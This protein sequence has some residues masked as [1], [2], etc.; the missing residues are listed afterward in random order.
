[1]RDTRLSEYN[2]CVY[3]YLPGFLAVGAME[4]GLVSLRKRLGTGFRLAGQSVS[5][6]RHNPGLAVY[7]LVGGVAMAAFVVTAIGGFVATGGSESLPIVVATLFGVY[8]GTSFLAAFSIA[9][10]SWAAR[11][12]FAGRDPS[13]TGAFR[14]AAGHLWALL[15][16]AVLSAVV[17]LLLRALEE[18]SDIVGTIITALLSL[19]WAALTYFVIPIIV[20]EDAGPTTM[21]QE[22][23]RLVRDTWGESLGSEFG[24]GIVSFLL[25]LPGIVALVAVFVISPDGSVFAAGIA[26]AGL[27]LAAGVLAG[28][29]LGAIAK[30]ALY[31]FAREGTAPAEFDDTVLERGST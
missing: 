10:L 28:Y 22:S 15:A 20:F 21:V 18:S 6:L 23:G 24:V 1:M 13:V 2:V 27:V 5:V 7:P 3:D 25:A 17:G 16:W 12:T 19:G 29:T 8:V 9:A 31:T 14:A 11:E 26:V 4:V 30:V